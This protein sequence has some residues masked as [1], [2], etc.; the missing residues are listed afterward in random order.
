MSEKKRFESMKTVWHIPPPPRYTENYDQPPAYHRHVDIGKAHFDLVK[1]EMD[2]LK[3]V[4]GVRV[5][6]P[7]KTAVVF[8]L[9]DYQ[10]VVFGPLR[11]RQPDGRSSQAYRGYLMIEPENLIQAVQ[12]L[13]FLG[14]KRLSEGKRMEYKLEYPW[15]VDFRD[16]ERL[17]EGTGGYVEAMY[18][19]G[20][21][22]QM[23]TLYADTQE[24]IEEVLRHL[25]EEANWEEVEQ[26]KRK[27]C[28]GL[29][30]KFPG[31]GS[32]R[33][34]HEGREYYSLEFNDHPGHSGD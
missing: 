1:K 6:E 5:G 9:A 14:K 2:D 3:Q 8:N 21:N 25:V 28:E 34:E 17:P 33:F 18:I 13:N 30:M 12:Q 32:K 22:D 7:G 19:K 11:T 31:H 20:P 26:G 27:V 16:P 15:A 23:I 24:E 29:R 4:E 10:Q